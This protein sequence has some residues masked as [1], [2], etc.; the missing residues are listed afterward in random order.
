MLYTEQPTSN[1]QPPTSNLEAKAAQSA[2]DTKSGENA[3]QI[4]GIS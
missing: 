4:K 3:L 2:L 1:L